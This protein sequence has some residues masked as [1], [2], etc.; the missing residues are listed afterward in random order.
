MQEEAPSLGVPL[1]V[2]REST[3]R[4]EAIDAGCAELAPTPDALAV[5][6]ER[7]Y[8]VRAQDSGRPGRNPFGDGRAARRIVRALARHL[9]I[10]KSEDAPG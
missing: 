8:A 1:L 9:N 4:P 3:E 6:L 2:L 5:M 10:R 7:K